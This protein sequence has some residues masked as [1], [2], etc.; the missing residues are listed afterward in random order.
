[1][2]DLFVIASG[3]MLGPSGWERPQSGKGLEGVDVSV[4][5]NATPI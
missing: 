4:L 2:D 3:S 1:M 5:M